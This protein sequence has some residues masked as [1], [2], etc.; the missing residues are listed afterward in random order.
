M[1]LPACRVQVRLCLSVDLVYYG[2]P[3][4]L[5]YDLV[6]CRE[7]TWRRSSWKYEGVESLRVDGDGDLLATATGEHGRASDRLSGD[8][9]AGGSSYRYRFRRRRRV[10]VR[11]GAVRCGR[12]CNDPVLLYATYLG[13]SG[14]DYGKGIVVDSSGAAYITGQTNPRSISPPPTLGAG[15]L[16]RRQQ[17]VR[18]QDHRGGVGLG[19]PPTWA[20]TV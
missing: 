3:Q 2:N 9:R 4:K 5:E 17:C 18:D 6:V 1:E 12:R 16:R 14:G 7:Q 11:A 13:G 19:T 15:Q 20:A 8:E 10:C